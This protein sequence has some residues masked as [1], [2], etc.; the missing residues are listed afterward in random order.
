MSGVIA[1]S[2]LLSLEHGK[3]ATFPGRLSLPAIGIGG[4]PRQ[5]S[6]VPLLR[7]AATA[8]AIATLVTQP[9]LELIDPLVQLG[10]LTSRESV[11]TGT[12]EPVADLVRLAAEAQGLARRDDTATRGLIDPLLDLVDPDH[13]LPDGTA[14]WTLIVPAAIVALIPLAVIA[15]I[16]GRSRNSGQ[17]GGRNGD[18]NEKLAH[19]QLLML[20]DCRSPF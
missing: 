18:G 12:L 15:A 16:L 13:Q 19:N 11:T 9:L 6:G 2:G 3:K 14:I 20:H 8:V 10:E 1:M 17:G 4:T 7:L 5:L